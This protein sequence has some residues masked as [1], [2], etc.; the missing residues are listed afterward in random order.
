MNLLYGFIGH[1][2]RGGAS[3][4]DGWLPGRQAL[5][6]SIDLSTDWLTRYDA[7]LVAVPDFRSRFWVNPPSATHIMTG[8]VVR[9]GNALAL[10]YDKGRQEMRYAHVLRPACTS[11]AASSAR[12]TWREHADELRTALISQPLE[13]VTIAMVSPDPWSS[14][15]NPPSSDDD[16]D[17]RAFDY[18]P[19]RWHE[20][21]LDPVGIQILTDTHL[22]KASDL[23]DW[24]T[25]R[26]DAD[27]TLVE[28]RDL[29][30]WYGGA[31]RGEPVA[32]AVLKQA[33]RDFG[34]AILTS[35][36]AKELALDGK[37]SRNRTSD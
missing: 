22:G 27:H 11:L 34:S 7:S 32:R 26:L 17:G 13:D 9:G 28:A 20:F 35:R 30:P 24:V 8:D 16:A 37:P 12:M 18:H 3:W 15:Q 25:T 33:R 2:P 14:L 1:R 36:R 5:S 31:A 29:E 23:S 19:E 6:A 10:G 21:T 4:Y